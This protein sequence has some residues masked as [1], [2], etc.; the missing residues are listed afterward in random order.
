MEQ[1]VASSSSKQAAQIYAESLMFEQNRSHHQNIP[2][3]N[4]NSNPNQYC[5]RDNNCHYSYCQHSHNMMG[6]NQ[7]SGSGMLSINTTAIVSPSSSSSTHYVV[8]KT[9]VLAD[10]E[11]SSSGYNSR[12]ELIPGVYRKK[13]TF[14]FGKCRVCNDRATGVHYGKSTCEGCKVS[15]FNSLYIVKYSRIEVM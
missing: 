14:P 9:P 10:E 1:L 4:P 8:P 13:S 2:N 12:E 15:I 11:V 5:F 7:Y 3:P 6:H